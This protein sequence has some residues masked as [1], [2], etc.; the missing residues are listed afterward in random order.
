M[1]IGNLKDQGNKGNNFP[2]QLKNLQLL[3]LIGDNLSGLATETT[4]ASVDT[5]LTAA[6]RTPN[7]LRDGGIGSTPGGV[8]S[9]SIANVGTVDGTVDGQGI[10]PGVT[11]NFDGGSLNNTLSSLPYDATGTVFIITWIS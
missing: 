8:Y 6:S 1:S 9:F 7:I 10:P 2:Y 4:L 11:I 5:K 3:G